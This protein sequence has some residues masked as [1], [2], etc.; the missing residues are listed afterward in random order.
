[1]VVADP[2]YL[3]KVAAGRQ[4]LSQLRQSPVVA[5]RRLLDVVVQRVRDVDLG[6]DCYLYSLGMPCRSQNASDLVH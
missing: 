5:G 3:Y 6:G 4:C 1:M 2:Q